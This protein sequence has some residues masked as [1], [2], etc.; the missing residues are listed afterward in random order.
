LLHYFKKAGVQLLFINGNI[1][2]EFVMCFKCW[3]FEVW[4]ISSV[5]FSKEG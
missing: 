3:A 1:W 5:Q 2:V 4:F